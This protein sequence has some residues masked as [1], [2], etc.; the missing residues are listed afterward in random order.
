MK[1]VI[2]HYYFDVFYTGPPRRDGISVRFSLVAFASSLFSQNLSLTS[3]GVIFESVGGCAGCAGKEVV[4]ITWPPLQ[5]R[6]S[7]PQHC[8]GPGSLPVVGS[9]EVGI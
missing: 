4:S 6:R 5:P 2:R 3:E 8:P 7:L 9:R 1:A